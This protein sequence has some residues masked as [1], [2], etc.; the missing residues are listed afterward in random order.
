MFNTAA[1]S[2]FCPKDSKELSNVEIDIDAMWKSRGYPPDPTESVD[3]LL[4]EQC[5]GATVCGY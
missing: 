3:G 4:P 5:H 1:A 2:F